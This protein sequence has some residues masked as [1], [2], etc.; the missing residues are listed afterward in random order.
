MRIIRQADLVPVPWKNGGGI[1]REALRWPRDG[2]TWD[3]RLSFAQV[4]ASG[5]FSDFSGYQRILVLLRGPGLTLRFGD[6]TSQ[7]LRAPGDL[8]VFDGGITTHG[9]LC[10]GPCADLNLIVAHG[11]CHADARIAA[12]HGR[13]VEPTLPRVTCLVVPLDGAVA[14]SDEAGLPVTLGPGDIAVGA[15]A[16]LHA[17]A[18]CRVFIA[19]ITDNSP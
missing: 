19:R 13:L 17:G 8:A 18:P 3:W 9:E 10:E 4:D 5:P 2:E 14:L 12:L 6:G 11:R 7:R 1:T 16:D 15:G